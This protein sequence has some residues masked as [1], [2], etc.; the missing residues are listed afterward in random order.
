M[1]IASSLGL[2]LILVALLS[3][4]PL[5]G[6]LNILLIPIGVIGVIIGVFTLDIPGI[7]MCVAAMLL[8]L[9]RFRGRSKV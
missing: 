6:W 8:G 2:G 9:Y 3:F 5:L 7:A 4:I 1:V